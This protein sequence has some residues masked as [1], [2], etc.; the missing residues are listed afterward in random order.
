MSHWSGLALEAHQRVA[1]SPSIARAA[2]FPLSVSSLEALS[3]MDHCVPP[4]SKRLDPSG[5]APNRPKRQSWL[6]DSR[7]RAASAGAATAR[8]AALMKKR[9]RPSNDN[10]L[11]IPCILIRT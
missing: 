9:A 10:L 2:V 8:A 1:G 11:I 6:N 7:E 3:W 4:G 5:I